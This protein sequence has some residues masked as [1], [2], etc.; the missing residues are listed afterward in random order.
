MNVT[1]FDDVRDF[2]HS[3][4]EVT[5]GHAYKTIALLRLYGYQLRLPQSRALGHNLYEL[6]SRGTQEVRIFYTFHSGT[7]ILLHAFIKKSQKT[8]NRELKI[9][10]TRLPMLTKI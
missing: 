4:S 1:Y 6:R 8:P 3:L 7:A 10:R 2:L 9:A 5:G